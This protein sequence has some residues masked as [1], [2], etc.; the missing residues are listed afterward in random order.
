V[1]NASA[2][3]GSD[4][5]AQLFSAMADRIEDLEAALQRERAMGVLLA[6]DGELYGDVQK[7]V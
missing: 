5:D 2:A 7:T 1:L 4:D 6:I 3:W